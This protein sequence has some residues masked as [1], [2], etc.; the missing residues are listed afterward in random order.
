MVYRVHTR[1]A[2]LALFKGDELPKTLIKPDSMKNEPNYR[3]FR[4]MVRKWN[5]SN[6][7]KT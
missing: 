7:P 5:V 4:R 2:Q 3:A 1:L 6:K